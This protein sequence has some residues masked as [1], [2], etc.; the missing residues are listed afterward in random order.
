[1]TNQKFSEV[2]AEIKKLEQIDN[3]NTG[4]IDRQ[5]TLKEIC[6]NVE[7]VDTKILFSVINFWATHYERV[8]NGF[9]KNEIECINENKL[10][11]GHIWAST[12]KDH[13]RFSKE[14]REMMT[15]IIRQ[16][17][18]ENRINNLNKKMGI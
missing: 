17:K 11:A 15:Q 13:F 10:A 6:G 2:Q 9:Y 16:Q 5:E 14:L 8:S 12:A 18:S 4:M 3:Y 1:M 7:H